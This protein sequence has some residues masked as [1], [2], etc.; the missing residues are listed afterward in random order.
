MGLIKS[1][2]AIGFIIFIV[3]GTIFG[4]LIGFAITFIMALVISGMFSRIEKEKIEKHVM[5]R[6]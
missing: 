5:K 1:I 2:L 3:L 4:G 6:C